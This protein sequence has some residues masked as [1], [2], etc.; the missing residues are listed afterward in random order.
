MDRFGSVSYESARYTADYVGKQVLLDPVIWSGKGLQ[1]PFQLMSKGLG[2]DF[3]D[4]NSERLKKVKGL[5]VRGAPVGL[6]RYYANRLGIKL[7]AAER[8]VVEQVP[9]RKRHEWIGQQ[10]MDL[11]Q[12]K[13]PRDQRALDELARARLTKKGKI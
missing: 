10:R 3:A 2:R 8:M 4:A 9:S 7:A 6:P 11:E 5:T 13:A 1:R 12:L